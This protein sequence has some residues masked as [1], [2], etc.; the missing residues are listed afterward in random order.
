MIISAPYRSGA[1]SLCLHLAET[2]Q[3]KF[4][5]QV[6]HN[7]VE[8]TRIEDKNLVH[9]HKNQPD[10]SVDQLVDIFCD[11][12]QHVVLNNSMPALI[13]ASE[14]FIVRKDLAQ[15]YYSLY[16]ILNKIYPNINKFAVETTFKKMSWF[17]S[18][19][20]AYCKKSGIK[21]LILEEQ[22]WY[23]SKSQYE[24]PKEFHDLIK[25]HVDFVKSFGE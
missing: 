23:I 11:H 10:H 18:I 15:S 14:Y 19:L 12:S 21:P 3:L 17:N 25:M 20:M 1:T 22:P 24:I 5:G 9:E 4:A 13:P 7:S 2:H 16:L 8:W 6:D